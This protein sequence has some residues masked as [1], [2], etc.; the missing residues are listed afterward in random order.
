MI[1][2]LRK[3]IKATARLVLVTYGSR[4]VTIILGN[5]VTA[6]L[7]TMECM[8]EFRAERKTLEIPR[9]SSVSKE[10]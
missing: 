4:A 10:L 1:S 3:L 7:S 9:H 6:V 8:A 2:L 5:A